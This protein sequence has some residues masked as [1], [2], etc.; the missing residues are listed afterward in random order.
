MKMPP[1]CPVHEQYSRRTC[2]VECVD[3]RREWNRISA[4]TRVLNYDRKRGL[5]PQRDLVHDNAMRSFYARLRL[6]RR[7][8]DEPLCPTCKTNVTESGHRQCR[9]CR[10]IGEKLRKAKRAA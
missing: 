10:W 6:V 8:I 5:K 3:Q 2:G 7:L 4:H 1:F 9:R